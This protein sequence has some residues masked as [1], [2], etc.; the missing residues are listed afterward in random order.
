MKRKIEASILIIS[1]LMVMVSCAKESDVDSS[2]LPFFPQQKQVPNAY[3]DALLVGKLVLM[4]GCLRVNTNEG[5]SPLIIWPYGF[6]LRENANT[7]EILDGSGQLVVQV[8][9]DVRV[10]GGE[11]QGEHLKE[12][13]GQL[14]PK[15]C[16]GP[17]WLASNEIVRD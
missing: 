4:N 9:D 2:D 10:G 7:I 11:I 12:Y 3:M 17:Y 6:S 13:D 5:T 1:L 8:G 14:F 16:S 15:E